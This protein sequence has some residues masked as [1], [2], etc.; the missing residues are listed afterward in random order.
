MIV[1]N[2]LIA[3][4]PPSLLYQ[5]TQVCQQVWSEVVKNRQSLYNSYAVCSADMVSFQFSDFF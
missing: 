2:K 4:Y 5:L 3:A 1:I